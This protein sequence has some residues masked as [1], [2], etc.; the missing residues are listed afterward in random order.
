MST[1]TPSDEQS[2]PGQLLRDIWD[3]TIKIDLFN[4]SMESFH[5][6]LYARYATVWPD[7]PHPETTEKPTEKEQS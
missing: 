3:L 5:K 7:P 1:N 4:A 2:K 6:E